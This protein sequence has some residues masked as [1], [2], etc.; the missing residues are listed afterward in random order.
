MSDGSLTMGR[1]ERA[2]SGEAATGAVRGDDAENDSRAGETRAQS[3]FPF[4]SAVDSEPHALMENPAGNREGGLTEEAA[5]IEPS[6][7]LALADFAAPR[8]GP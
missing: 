4:D 7:A 1:A 3:A 8:T 6:R 2:R 5:Q